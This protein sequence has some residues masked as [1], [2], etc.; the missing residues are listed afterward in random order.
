MV[1][2]QRQ[3]FVDGAGDNQ[4]G[5]NTNRRPVNWGNQNNQRPPIWGN[6]NTQIPNNGG[7][8]PTQQGIINSG[9][10][11]GAQNEQEYENF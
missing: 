4:G 10:R 8:R 2:D 3:H 7:R 5:R 1:N 9:Q 11:S 6:Q